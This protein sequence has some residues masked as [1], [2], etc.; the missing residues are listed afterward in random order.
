MD[1][2]LRHV[3][4]ACSATFARLRLDESMSAKT[5]VGDGFLGECSVA[6][7]DSDRG[8]ALRN[9]GCSGMRSQFL[10]AEPRKRRGNAHAKITVGVGSESADVERGQSLLLGHWPPTATTKAIGVNSAVEQRE[11]RWSGIGDTLEDGDSRLTEVSRCVIETSP[12][13]CLGMI[14]TVST[15]VFQRLSPFLFLNSGISMTSFYQISPLFLHPGG[16][17][18]LAVLTSMC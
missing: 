17:P 9:W 10:A 4:H 2:L 1:H 7:I 8:C 13:Y 3:S 11:L 6:V 15:V 18:R 16:P 14:V 12:A 5:P